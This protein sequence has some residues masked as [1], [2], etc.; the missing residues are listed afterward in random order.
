MKFGY[1]LITC[2]RYPGD[3][4]TDEELYDESLRLAEE[5]ERLGFDSLWVSEHHFWDDSWTPSPLT[6][7]SAMAART[8]KIQLGTGIVQAPLYK[9]VMLAEEAATVDLISKG[10]LVLG[11]GLGWHPLEFDAMQ[12][13]LSD[14]GARIEETI[15]LLRRAW[16]SGRVTPE[17]LSKIHVPQEGFEMF[18]KPSR[19]GGP[20]IW[21]AGFAKAGLRRAGR[22]ADGFLAY[23]SSVSTYARQVE[24]IRSELQD[25]RPFEFGL[26][27]PC[28]AWND[29][30]ATE[31][32]RDHFYYATW[33][34]IDAA[35]AEADR[36]AVRTPGSVPA[37]PPF[38]GED[39][40][41][42]RDGAIH[43]LSAKATMSSS[44]DGL[45]GMFGTPAEVADS[46][47]KYAELVDGDLHF[48]AKLY[49]PGMTFERHVEA[50]HIFAE[51]VIPRVQR[52]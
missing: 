43:T 14:R 36:D 20:P 10:R 22:L 47:L 9:P 2:Q 21:L 52:G 13:S 1:G 46:I 3:A 17:G 16:S 35:R 25:G 45:V 48:V 18:P 34:Y 7:L 5:A 40:I 29:G 12:A 50:L 32:V 26:C 11:M 31:A 6:V 42:Q 30:P 23:S 24:L 8:T 15:E 37:P 41:R 39:Q 19:P 4:R 38:G 27:I 49:M 28:L 51:E 33:K 44:E